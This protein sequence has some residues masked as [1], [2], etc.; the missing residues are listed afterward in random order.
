MVPFA[1]AEKFHR[2]METHGL[3]PEWRVYSI[4]HTVAPDE[5]RDISRWLGDVLIKVVR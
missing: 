1:A 5:I 3:S 4:G 2:L